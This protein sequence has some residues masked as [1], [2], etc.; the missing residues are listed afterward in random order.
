[1][2]LGRLQLAALVASPMSRVVGSAGVQGE[3]QHRRLLLEDPHSIVRPVLHILFLV[4]EAISD[5]RL[6]EPLLAQV[7]V[8]PLALGTGQLPPTHGMHKAT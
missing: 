2:G 5:D 1:M 4:V 7:L 3:Q 6:P 8:Q